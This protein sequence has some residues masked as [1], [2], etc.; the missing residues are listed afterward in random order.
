[1]SVRSPLGKP[2][3][4]RFPFGELKRPQYDVAVALARPAHS[5]ETADHGVVEPDQ[6]FAALVDLIL[7]THAAE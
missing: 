1:L 3:G 2:W 6:A 4:A 5:P 7:V